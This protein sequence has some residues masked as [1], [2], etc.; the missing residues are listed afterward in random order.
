MSGPAALRPLLLLPNALRSLVRLLRLLRIAVPLLAPGLVVLLLLA[1]VQAPWHRAVEAIL[2][3]M[4]MRTLERKRRSRCLLNEM[5]KRGKGSKY[6]RQT[7]QTKI[8]EF[9]D[10]S[11]AL[12]N[13][14]LR[15]T[16]DSGVARFVTPTV[17]RNEGNGGAHE[18][19]EA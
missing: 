11:W 15:S 13:L 1:L 9:L 3:L 12:C 14:I 19:D 17:S 6:C 18:G 5:K 16:N 10:T 2:G 4:T 8:V 7:K